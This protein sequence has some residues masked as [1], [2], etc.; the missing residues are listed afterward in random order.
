MRKR[1][2]LVV[3]SPRDCPNCKAKAGEQNCDYQCPSCDT[4][5]CSKCYETDP[6]GP[7][8]YIFCP[9]CKTKLFFPATLQ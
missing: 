6:K 8:N 1:N 4:A 3:V 7:G 9:A 5:F 2:E